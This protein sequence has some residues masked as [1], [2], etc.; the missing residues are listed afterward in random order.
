MPGSASPRRN[1]Q[2][3][4]ALTMEGPLRAWYFKVWRSSSFCSALVKVL[5]CVRLYRKQVAGLHS[6][7]DA[8]DKFAELERFL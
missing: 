3:I 2:Y 5:L 6:L 8:G 1:K 7:P 4:T